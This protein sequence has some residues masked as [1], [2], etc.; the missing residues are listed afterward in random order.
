MNLPSVQLPACQFYALSAALPTPLGELPSPDWLQALLRPDANVPLQVP[1]A[2]RAAVRDML[3]GFGYRPTGRGKPS[4]EYLVAAAADGRLGSINAVVDAGNAV[5]L[6]SGVPISVVDLD[7]LEGPP[8]IVVPPEGA[9]YIF[10]LGGQTIG[11]GG[12]V[13]LADERG[14]CANAVKDAQR[15]KTSAS[16]QRILCVLW[17]AA[18]PHA[19]HGQ[20]AS[21]WLCE[22]LERLGG[23]V[24]TVPVVAS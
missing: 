19:E 21:A 16:T 11:I 23:V 22:I 12:L 15:S 14:P 9:D 13:C 18:G 4:S 17:G 24:T 8:R 7:R 5:S 10:N 6:H 1:A 2:L 20:R 3:R